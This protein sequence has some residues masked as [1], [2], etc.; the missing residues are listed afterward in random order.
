MSIKNHSFFWIILMMTTI[1]NSSFLF[2]Q[3]KS[4]INKI[5]GYVTSNSIPLKNVNVSIQGKSRRTITDEKGYYYI[6]ASEKEVIHFSFVGKKPVE[7]IVEDVTQFLNIKMIDGVNTLDE[8]LVQ[9]NSQEKRSVKNN[10]KLSKLKTA[11]GEIDLRSSPFASKIVKGEDLNTGA[12]D[13]IEA[14][15][16]RIPIYGVTYQGSDPVGNEGVTVG[17]G[18]KRVRILP[19]VYTMFNEGSGLAIW[20]VDGFVYEEAPHVDLNDIAYVAVLRSVGARTKYGTRGAGGVIVV[21]TKSSMVHKTL[22]T[23][24][25]TN[26]NQYQNNAFPYVE[27][28]SNAIDVIIEKS[29]SITSEKKLYDTYK[30]LSEEYQDSPSFYL[31]IANYFKQEKESNKLS[32]LVLS[33]MEK[34]FNKNAEA[35]KALAYTYQKLG[36]KSKALSIYNKI[37][38]LRPSYA[39]SFRDLANA[40]SENEEYENAWDMYMRYLRRG[41]KLEEKGIEQV[42]YNEMKY[43]YTQKK[44]I[45]KIRETFKINEGE[46]ETATS[47]IRV[48]FEWNT[49]EAEFL[50]EFVDPQLNSFVYE[51]SWATNSD[52]ISDGK[53]KGYSSNEFFIYDLNRGEWLINITYLGNKKYVPTYLKATVYKNWGRENQ[54][55][56][57]KLFKLN[58]YNYKMQL[59]KFGSLFR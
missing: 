56:N 16:G 51:H 17:H 13:L 4:N 32:L 50:L 7:V 25:G 30:T 15:R 28:K 47:D 14:I 3:S 5:Y 31:D 59:L 41:F 9:T 58:S 36:E 45:A 21:I 23:K 49:S 35:L 46:E 55:S 12:I 52:R 10:T 48:V 34:M 42:V 29:N 22:K 19:R 37:I 38:Y 1:G 11:Y 54:T 33:D 20:D 40:Y 57:I 26:E 53:L 44:E 18:K 24:L 39:Q 6:E 8:V 2:A 43:L 27:K